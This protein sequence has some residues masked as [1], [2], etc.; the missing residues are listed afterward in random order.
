MPNICLSILLVAGTWYKVICA[1][2]QATYKFK[3]YVQTTKK[4]ITSSWFVI[5]PYKLHSH[6]WLCKS[7]TSHIS[8]VLTMIL[9]QSFD[10]SLFNRGIKFF[11]FPHPQWLITYTLLKDQFN[12]LQILFLI[13]H[14]YGIYIYVTIHLHSRTEIH[15]CLYLK[16]T[17]M[18]YPETPS[19]WP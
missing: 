17:L 14:L 3:S 1:A 15:F 10:R 19:T 16:V 6:H 5:N 8:W 2:N 11:K 13:F 9:I 12:L 4:K 18:H 7:W